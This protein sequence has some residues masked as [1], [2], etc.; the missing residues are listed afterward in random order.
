MNARKIRGDLALSAGSQV[1]YKL[2]GF[3]IVAMLA[4]HLAPTSFGQLMFALSLAELLILATE[5]GTS[6]LLVREVAVRPDA[7][8][9]ELGAVLGAR[10]VMLAPYTLLVTAVA[11]AQ[12][13]GQAFVLLAAATYIA[14]RDISRS[15]SSVFVGLRRIG[16]S[17]VG[18]GSSLVLLTAGLMLVVV[19]G[20]GLG[21]ALVAYLTAG[22]WSVAVAGILIRL[23]VGA[24]R[25]VFAPATIWRVLVRALPLFG[26]GVMT[27]LHFKLDTILLGFLRTY[28]EVAA[29]KASATLLEASQAIVRPLTLIFLPICAHLAAI[30]A[31][32]QLGRSFERLSFAALGLGLAA[33]AVAWVAAE[34][35]ITTVYGEGYRD[36]ANLLRLHFA[37]TPAM[38]LGVVAILHSTAL[39]AERA[40]VVYLA[41]GVVLN[42]VADLLLIP[43]LGATGAALAT[44]AAQSISGI[45][46]FLHCRRR[47]AAARPDPVAAAAARSGS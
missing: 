9:T 37:A 13:T 29:Y 34:L 30:G 22:I 24:T 43:P 33:A 16:L 20:G 31:Y 1:A 45:G 28:P 25:P 46:L 14:L 21:A 23:Y 39:R 6:N 44:L 17:I 5:L 4:R 12:P 32:D 42:L 2:L 47:I 36:A 15:V 8:R 40:A 10:L 3:A 7:A 19:T 41:G 18:F 38:F 27:L 11:L 26:I 35:I